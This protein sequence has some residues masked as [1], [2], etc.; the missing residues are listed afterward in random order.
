[1]VAVGAD[2]SEVSEGFE[3]VVVVAETA[4]VG[5]AGE[6]TGGDGD[7]V[8]DFEVPVD[9]AACDDTGP[10]ADFDPGAQV[11]GDGSSEV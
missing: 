10:V 1:M 5:E 8:V 2:S 11:R 9:L 4:E 3:V 7:V 6:A